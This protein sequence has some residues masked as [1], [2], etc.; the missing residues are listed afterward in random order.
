MIEEPAIP[1]NLN[2]D[3]VFRETLFRQIPVYVTKRMRDRL[4]D[5]IPF[6]YNQRAIIILG[7]KLS[8]AL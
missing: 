2:I 3:M 6:G 4:V 1:F 7:Q 8:E 5:E